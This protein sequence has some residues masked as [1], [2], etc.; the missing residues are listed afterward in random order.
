MYR[1]ADVALARAVHAA[2][3]I[4][5]CI[6]G[7]NMLLLALKNAV[8]AK[9]YITTGAALLSAFFYAQHFVNV[10]AFQNVLV[11]AW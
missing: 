2:K 7:W 4:Q 10:V 6:A 3:F 9:I 11:N 8:L 5:R 1:F